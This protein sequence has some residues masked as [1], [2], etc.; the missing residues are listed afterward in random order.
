MCCANVPAL[1]RLPNTLALDASEALPGRM[2]DMARMA[3]SRGERMDGGGTTESYE[4]D[5]MVW[6]VL[7]LVPPLS[8][9]STI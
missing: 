5:R 4:I 8:P 9:G 7:L 6:R 2:E 3:V 1:V